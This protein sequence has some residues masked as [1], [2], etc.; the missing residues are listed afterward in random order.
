MPGK[1]GSTSQR[2]GNFARLLRHFG[3]SMEQIA[4]DEVP[5]IRGSNDWWTISG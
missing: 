5:A 1:R 4:L 2:R 3:I